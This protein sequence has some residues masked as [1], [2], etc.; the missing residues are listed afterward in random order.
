M[1]D[2]EVKQ[3]LGANIPQ[4]AP[5]NETAESLMAVRSSAQIPT[6]FDARTQWPNCVFAVRNQGNCGSCWSFSAT[7]SMW[8]IVQFAHFCI[9]LQDRLCIATNGATKVTLSPQN[10]VSCETRNFGCNGTSDYSY[11]KI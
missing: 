4:M 10:L 6:S 8:N 3:F 9:A 7:S 5:H 2:V 11:N 1:T